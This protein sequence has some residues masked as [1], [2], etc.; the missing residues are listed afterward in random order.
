MHG[1]SMR[2]QGTG[3]YQYTVVSAQC[4]VKDEIPFGEN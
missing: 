1:T 2:A 3:I 4:T